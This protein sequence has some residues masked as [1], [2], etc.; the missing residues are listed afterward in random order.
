MF[1]PKKVL[2]QNFLIDS[3]TI[4]K[5]I[6]ELD[7]N[8]DI[9]IEVGAG[10]GA[11]T[12]GLANEILGSDSYIYAIEIDTRFVDKLSGMYDQ[13]PNVEIVETDVLDW[14]PRFDSKDK[15]FKIIGSLPYYITSPILHSIV[16]MKKLPET[17]VLLIQKEVAENV[18]ANAPSSTYFSTFIQTFFK[19]RFIEKVDKSKFSPEPQVDGGIIKLTK[20]TQENIDIEKYEDFLHR[21]YKNPRKMLNKAFSNKELAASHINR[22]LRPQNY[23][24]EKW[25][26]FFNNLY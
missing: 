17:A 22:T 14:L 11:I 6:S 21:A 5:L 20:R 19:I 9:I 24:W 8:H 2:G 4:K 16:K 18:C 1:E 23:G 12:E 10:L 13:N 3:N 25:L 26:E 15:K 7:L